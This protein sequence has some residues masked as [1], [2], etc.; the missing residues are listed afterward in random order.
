M[1]SSPEPQLKVIWLEQF[2]LLCQ[3]N[4]FAKA[5]QKLDLSRQTLQRNIEHLEKAVKVALIQRSG[6]D[7]LVTPQGRLFYTEAQQVIHTM[8]RFSTQLKQHL[9]GPLQGSIHLA[10]QSLLSFYKLA[11]V[12][13]DFIFENP[14]VFLKTQVFQN[15][16]EIEQRLQDN[17]LDLALLDYQPLD[18]SLIVSRGTPTPYVIVSCP[19]PKRHWSTFSY[20]STGYNLPSHIAPPWNDNLH[21]RNLV[22]QTNTLNMLLPWTQSGIAAFMPLTLVQSYLEIGQL[23][24]VAD[25]PEEAFAHVYLCT[26]AL[27]NEN[28]AAQ[29]FIQQLQLLL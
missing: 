27:G 9:I 13:Q 28:P 1:T 26:S 20:V 15:S 21:P 18:E 6:K 14:D 2:L 23:A 22:A 3:E 5:A 4:D 29:M 10:W 24:I 17:K 19:Q 8:N 12:L 7:F 16:S 11:Q 25:P